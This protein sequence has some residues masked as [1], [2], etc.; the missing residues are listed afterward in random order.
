MKKTQGSEYW[1]SKA[2]RSLL[3]NFLRFHQKRGIRFYCKQYLR[4]I[5]KFV[6][7]KPLLNQLV[8]RI[9][10]Y[11]PVLRKCTGVA[12]SIQSSQNTNSLLEPLIFST[13]PKILQLTNYSIEDPDHGG[14]LRC[15]NIREA[16]RKY[17]EVETLSI[18]VAEN[19]FISK[20]SIG[21]CDKELYAQIGDRHL[22]DW[23]SAFFILQK[24][25]IWDAVCKIV[26]NFSPD[27]I[28]LEQPYLWPIYKKLKDVGA[29]GKD[30]LLIN[31][32]HNNEVELKRVIY[33]HIFEKEKAAEM[34]DSNSHKTS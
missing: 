1:K 4:R 5:E 25:H 2:L 15:Y 24:Q 34:V 31:S 3:Y 33:H 28:L 11:F 14:K 18:E 7:Q 22:S 8:L 13:R 27:A 16:L 19:E 20:Y 17:F 6:R 21:I 10:V 32:T 29:L 30:C 23:G 9:L 26:S 12:T